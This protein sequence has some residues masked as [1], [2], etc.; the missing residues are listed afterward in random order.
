MNDIAIIGASCLLPGATTLAELH[1]NLLAGTHA[2]GTPSA[3]RLHH[4]AADE[5][6]E[7]R[8]MAYLDRVDLFDHRFFGLSAREAELMDPHQRLLL[9]LVHTAL[10][11]ACY[12]PSR[13]RGSRTAVALSPPNQ[14]YD[15]LV[16]GFDPQ[17]MLG[18]LPAA[19][20]ARV[21]YL[22]DFAG[23]AMVV[24]TA[25][26]SGL[27]AVVTAVEQLR[28]G[29]ATLAIAGGISVNAVPPTRE[30]GV[31]DEID[32]PDEACRPFDAAA[33][34]TVGGEGGG[35]FV[36]KRL[37]D[38]L[39][40]NDNVLAV[41]KG[42]AVNHNGFRA[43]SMGAPSAVAQAEVIAEAWRDA[44]ADPATASYVECHGSGTRLG[45]VVEVNGLQS[46]YG[47]S[48]HVTIGSVKG[49]IGHLDNA[50][51]VAGLL[52]LLSGLRHG[53]RYPSLGF[54][55]PNPMI[56]FG[57]LAVSTRSEPWPGTPRRGAVSSLGFTG[58]NVH[59]VLEQAPDVQRA[60]DPE[61]AE[62]VTVSGRTASALAAYRDTLAEFV[63][64][65]PH[66]LAEIAHALNRGRDDGPFRMAFVADNRDELLKLLRAEPLP[67]QPVET[68]RP[69]VLL[70]GGDARID[71]VSWRE[72]TEAFPDLAEDIDFGSDPAVTLLSRQYACH[73]LLV[74]LGLPDPSMA[75]AGAGNVA[76]DLA[77]GLLSPAEAAVAL[78]SAGPP[79]PDADGLEWALRTWADAGSVLVEVGSGST[80]A[81]EIVRLRPEMA[82]LPLLGNGG[83]QGLLAA[84]YRQGVAID[85]DS[86]YADRP[87]RRIEAPVTILEPVRCWSRAP[88]RIST[89]IAAPA[90]ATGTADRIA[91]IWSDV[92]KESG[93]GPGSDYFELGGNSIAGMTVLRGIEAEFGVRLKF[94]DLY[95]NRTLAELTGVVDAAVAA[96][97]PTR[98][99]GHGVVPIPRD[100]PVPLSA[101]QQQLWFLHQVYEG[102]ALYT[103]PADLRLRGPLDPQVFEAALRAV[104][105]RHEILRTRIVSVDGEPQGVPG[106]ADFPFTVVDLSDRT[107]QERDRE[108]IRMVQQA[109]LTP[110]DLTQGPLGIVSLIR[111]AEEDHL[112]LFPVHHLAYDGG[113]SVA[114]SPELFELYDAIAQGRPADLPVLPFQFADFAAWQRDWLSSDAAAVKRDYWRNRLA[115]APVLDV[116]TDRPRPVERS[117]HGDVVKRAAGMEL[118][119]QIRQYA[120]RRGTTV[121]AAMLAAVTAF[122]NRWTGQED[123]VLGA[124]TT[125]RTAA[126]TEHLIGFFNNTVP[127]RVAVDGGLDFD[128]AVTRC[129]VEAAAVLDNEEIPFETIVKDVGARRDPGRNPLFDVAY[130]HQ[131][132][133]SVVPSLPGVT[134][135]RYSDDGVHGVAPQTAKFD[136]TIGVNDY[137]GTPMELFFEF[138]VD[139]F[140][141]TTMSALL[142]RFCLLL[143]AAFTRPSTTIG[144]L[145]A[146][147]TDSD[148]TL[149]LG[150]IW[151]ELLE[152]ESVQ[153]QDNFFQIGGD[154]LLAIRV[155]SRA[156]RAGIQLRPQD[157]TRCQT[158]AELAEFA[159]KTSA[160]VTE[161]GASP[162]MPLQRDFFVR[163][164]SKDAWAPGIAVRTPEGITLGQIQQI[165][166][167]LVAVHEVLRS[168]FRGNGFV[169]YAATEHR[170]IVDQVTL[171]AD[172]DEQVFI[173][174]HHRTIVQNMSLEHGP[175]VRGRFF[176]RDDGTG[177]LVLAVHHFVLDNK[178]ATTLVDDMDEA[179]SAITAGKPIPA[180]AGDVSAWRRWTQTL[181]D[182][183]ASPELAAEL[184]YWDEVART[185][186]PEIPLPGQ[187]SH[188]EFVERYVTA[189]RVPAAL[190]GVETLEPAICAAAVGVARWRGTDRACF[191]MS[192]E[193]SE[194]AF[195]T[196]DRALSAG[197]FTSKYPAT[198]LVRPELAA[199]DSLA[200]VTKVV[201]GVPND[202]VGYGMLRHLAPGG[203]EVDA[204]RALPEPEIMFQYEAANPASMRKGSRHF[205]P[206]ETNP[207]GD[208]DALGELG[209]L[210]IAMQMVEDEF[211]VVLHCPRALSRDRLESLLDEIVRALGEL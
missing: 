137:P 122:L 180:P 9:Q 139:L 136:L 100:R 198:F 124:P 193:P 104:V 143:E 91:A 48:G 47:R 135:T 105:D 120:L 44:G 14:G 12:A 181:N 95:E 140:D 151:R 73:R 121:F 147:R 211:R 52:K 197:W 51:G 23:P 46:V 165:V 6:A 2:F 116:P 68:A 202:G 204:F 81:A 27:S 111:L 74:K 55:T 80:L 158:L 10:E 93:I 45:D 3:D 208:Y 185:G 97:G 173:E 79:E 196:L 85:W 42:V 62:L 160:P 70:F 82:P 195:G 4:S 92:L 56:D 119:D 77:R 8:R 113:S 162:L 5:T 26:S 146:A 96:A 134:S 59:V 76:V 90:K 20:A 110:I 30:I 24:D 57:S 19:T 188:I 182:K 18:L 189:D 102:T 127:L 163:M 152:L 83:V 16:D 1:R 129:T 207:I 72:L 175:L 7:Y 107:E 31:V 200:A 75:G 178:T 203:P 54:T 171:P 38:A 108:T 153:P 118:S 87:I 154:S 32:S 34:G 11:N 29:Q 141:R 126:G 106:P 164:T 99:S 41:I 161:S 169:E 156:A 172:V 67:A 43:P 112:F 40:D 150:G 209:F 22:F 145:P 183:S 58:T 170:E 149:V 61:T 36:L 25:C 177:L 166:R 89:P 98:T 138:S 157:I 94:L 13:L 206:L 37:A 71:D 192:G 144:E 86:Y 114:F 155:V 84:V 191:L 60:E 69:V 176:R 186:R 168:R 33:N 64:S 194:T 21:S 101:G 199:R 130:L 159:G 125:G 35:V 28:R 210:T 49:N 103:V 39:A 17:Q 167:N 78:S 148:P 50:A 117:H 123:I 179:W 190:H 174:K 187:A 66:S 184:P 142:D 88:G 115:G 205:V 53:T 15:Q 63:T 131:N 128:T 132:S 201:A 133:P 65:S 109:A